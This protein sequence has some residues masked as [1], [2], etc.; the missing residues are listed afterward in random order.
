M[1]K[2]LIGARGQLDSSQMICS[3]LEE[4]LISKDNYYAS[5]EKNMHEEHR[6]E[7]SK[8]N[9]INCGSYFGRNAGGF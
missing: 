8:G 2:T 3:S 1:K 6:C 7:L 9:I 5:R 4:Q